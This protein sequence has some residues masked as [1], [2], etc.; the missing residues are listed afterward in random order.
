MFLERELVGMGK[1]VM[2]MGKLVHLLV[3]YCALC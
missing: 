2:L 3:Y 1:V